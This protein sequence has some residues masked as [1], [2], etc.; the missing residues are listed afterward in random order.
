[1]QLPRFYSL[2]LLVI[3][4]SLWLGCSN[5]NQ[6]TNPQDPRLEKQIKE[7]Y[8]RAQ[9]LSATAKMD[10]ALT[11]LKEA[12]AKSYILKNNRFIAKVLLEM[13]SLKNKKGDFN[14]AVIDLYEILSLTNPEQDTLTYSVV[15]F[16]LGLNFF[17][18]NVLVS[19]FVD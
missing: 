8:Q 11:V 9:K 4:C 6:T 2:G 16:D 19:N 5:P 1:M 17:K 18:M 12:A 14:D 15:Y 13:A 7:L 3:I 10:S